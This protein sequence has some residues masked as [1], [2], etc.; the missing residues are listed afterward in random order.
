MSKPPQQN[1]GEKLETHRK[2]RTLRIALIALTLSGSCVAFVCFYSLSSADG[3]YYDPGIGLAANGY[4]LFEKGQYRIWGTN[5]VQ[6]VG[7]YSTKGKDV[8]VFHNSG[9]RT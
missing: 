8:L 1:R 4:L 5:S 3:V 7:S 2:R 9:G 6:F